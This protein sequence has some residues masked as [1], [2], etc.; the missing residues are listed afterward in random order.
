M[1]NRVFKC[2]K[3]A[4]RFKFTLGIF[5]VLYKYLDCAVDKTGSGC[6]TNYW[7]DCNTNYRI[8]P[9]MLLITSWCKTLKTDPSRKICTYATW[10]KPS[11][12][13]YRP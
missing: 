6:N 1:V 3:L 9:L 5:V 7:G 4:V 11:F 2:D 8:I 13:K 12:A 10:G